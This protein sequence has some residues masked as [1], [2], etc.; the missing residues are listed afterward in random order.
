MEQK[1]LNYMRRILGAGILI[2]VLSAGSAGVWLWRRHSWDV[3]VQRT[4]RIGWALLPPLEVRGD[5]GRPSGLAVE[6]LRGAAARRGIRLEWVYTDEDPESALRTGRVDLWPILTI[7][8]E[9]RKLF[10]IS[11]PLLETDHCLLVRDDS[12]YRDLTDLASARIGTSNLT[13]DGPALRRRFSQA[14]IATRPSV[15]NLIEDVCA[16]LSD[17]AYMNEYSALAALLERRDCGANGLR[18]ISMMQ[19]RSRLGIGATFDAAPIARALRDE[20]ALA[21]AEHKLGPIAGRWGYLSANLESISAILE[22][23]R[24]ELR[25]AA[26]A[27]LFALLLVM[28]IFQAARIRRERNR[29]RHAEAALRETE[30]TLRLMAEHLH[31]AVATFDMER[32]VTYVNRAF[33]RLTGYSTVSLAS[34]GTVEQARLPWVHPAHLDQV[35]SCWQAAFGGQ[36]VHAEDYRVVTAGGDVKWITATWGPILDEAGNQ[37]GVLCTGRDITARKAAE[38]TLRQTSLR[39]ATL[40]NNSPLAVIEWSDHRIVN[41]LGGAQQLFGWT[42]D[43]VIGKTLHD[44]RWVHEDDWPE[45]RS[46]MAAM[47][48][49]RPALCRNRNYRKDGSIVYCEWYNSVLPSGA[50]GLPAGLSLVLDITERRHAEEALRRA[51]A[52]LERRVTERTLELSAANVRLQDLDRLKSQFLASMSHELRT[53]LNSIIGFGS[54]LRQELAGPLNPEQKKQLDIICK[55]SRHLLTL[56]NDLL[57]VS[58]IE[59]GRAD[60]QSEPFNFNDVAAEVTQSLMP[61]AGAKGLDVAVDIPPEGIQLYQDRKRTLQLLLNLVH[62]AV[63]FTASGGVRI[64]ARTA[65]QRL[66]VAV[67]DSGIGIKAEHLGMLFEAFRQVD[68]SARKVYEGTGLGLYLCKK[69][70]EL[71]GGE[72]RVESEY[73]KG[74]RFEFE[75]PLRSSGANPALEP[76]AEAMG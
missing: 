76:K 3:A 70:L 71:M 12:R 21:A 32:R 30:R 25:L 49:R 28:A 39:L 40:L 47:S 73:G 20:V 56:I 7:T 27:A 58:R 52:E 36:A 64:T 2:A 66:V 19:Q 57:D 63:K 44:F 41:W 62:N 74:S 35:Q 5:D 33:E 51:H 61:L 53:P 65:A 29:T 59:A 23:R 68:G 24:R 50:D 72:I 38:Q 6:L 42:A 18:W 31:E 67:E 48:E 11:D 69:L 16:G 34:R 75:L 15:R 22:S 14:R 4:Y 17:A 8:P 55:S 54:L 60:L 9:R 1:R 46:A 37:I 13:I 10:Y 45:V 43:E 26:V